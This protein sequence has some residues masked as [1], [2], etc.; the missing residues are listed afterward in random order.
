MLLYKTLENPF[1]PTVKKNIFQQLYLI[2][3]MITCPFNAQLGA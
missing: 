1:T 2:T 3:L